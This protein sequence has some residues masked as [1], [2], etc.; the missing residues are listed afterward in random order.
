M[1]AIIKLTETMLNK[2]IIDANK[3]VR[4]FAKTKFE[5]DYKS[6]QAGQKE[7]ISAKYVEDGKEATVSFYKA[8][9]RG[10]NR[11]SIS[12]LRKKAKA[13]Q[14]VSLSSFHGEFIKIEIKDAC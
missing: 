1:R 12:G 7:K 4:E 11:I 10:D 14:I 5:F 9:G 13:G 2:S 3:T 8:K 6:A